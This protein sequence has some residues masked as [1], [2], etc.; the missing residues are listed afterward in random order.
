MNKKIGKIGAFFYI[1]AIVVATVLFTIRDANRNLKKEVVI[2]AGSEIKIEEFFNECPD[3]A[4]FLSDISVID[5]NIPAVYKLT[6]FYGEA[7]EK[8]VILRI[9]DHTKPKGIALPRN[10]YASRRWPDASECVGYL[11]DLSGI[12]KI[13]YLNGVPDYQYTGDYSVPVAVTDWYD[14]TTIIDVPFHVIDDHNA[15]VFYGIH[16]IN[17]DNSA[18]AVID[19]FNGV[20]WKDDYDENPMVKVDDSKV[21]IGEVGK[22]T[23]TYIAVDAAGNICKQNATVNIKVPDAYD[24]YY[25]GGSAWDSITHNETYE[26]AMSLVEE[27]RGDSDMETAYNI[28]VWVHSHIYYEAAIGEQ[29]FESATYQALT[30]HSADCYGYYA[31]S[32]LLLDCAG[33]PNMMVL[34]YPVTYN[35]HFWN[36]VNLD[37]E[38]YHCDSTMFMNHPGLY[39]MQTD[40]QIMD[41]RHSFNG[42][43]LPVRAG[44]TP[45]Y[46]Y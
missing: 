8:D 18:D 38:W 30:K 20:T 29:T 37:G 4:R 11:Y 6:V 35:G 32:K 5:T 15:P 34:R 9:E 10:Q 31:T 16:D 14:N 45:E 24:W 46:T 36:L 33:I 25:G 41:T 7:F 22:Y 40:A 13:E 12:A 39:F 44:G 42:S 28:F 26:Y 3:D 17:I 21:K 19:Y 2:E 27:L 23:V 1:G 43:M